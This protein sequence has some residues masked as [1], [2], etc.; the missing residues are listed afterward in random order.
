MCIQ[1]VKM[2]QAHSIM[3]FKGIGAGKKKFFLPL[4]EFFLWV[5]CPCFFDDGGLG[6]ENFSLPGML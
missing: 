1:Y 3:I 6:P 4:W 5:P 2:Y